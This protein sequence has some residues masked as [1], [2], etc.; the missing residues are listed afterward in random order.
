MAADLSSLP[1]DQQQA[2][3]DGPALRPP[4][5]TQSNFDNPAN[6]NAIPEAVIPICLVFVSLSIALRSYARLLI[7]KR[8]DVEDGEDGLIS[9]TGPGPAYCPAF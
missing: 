9:N 4:A 2:I 3:L 6:H 5:G 7:A 8:I 1:P